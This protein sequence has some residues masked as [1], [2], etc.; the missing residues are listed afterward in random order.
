MASG[1]ANSPLAVSDS[2]IVIDGS[3]DRDELHRNMA[4]SSNRLAH[5]RR[6]GTLAEL[7][8]RMVRS[9][10][11]PVVRLGAGYGYAANTYN[12]GGT[13]NRH[14]WGPD[15][16]V[17]ASFTIFDGNRRREIRN[18]LREADNA[19]LRAAEIETGLEADLATFWHA[20]RN[21]LQ[22]LSLER[23]NLKAARQNYAAAN[24]QYVNDVLAGIEL[25]EAQKS[26]L[27]GE[28]RLLVALYNTKLCE[29]SLLQV[30]GGVL[31]YLE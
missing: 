5:A 6:S 31:Q 13:R 27:D 28:E 8:A 21:N 9:R 25:R 23:E 3:L 16:G 17:T 22:L 29:I 19:T 30:S 1:D 26:L 4:A 14:S 2:V 12:K 7:D 24:D 10:S 20:Y 11:Y 15:A 18:A